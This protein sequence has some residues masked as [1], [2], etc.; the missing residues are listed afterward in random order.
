MIKYTLTFC[1]LI[2]SIFASGQTNSPYFNTGAV[3]F[4]SSAAEIG[5]YKNP[6]SKDLV[7]ISGREYGIIKRVGSNDEPFLSY[8]S[9]D[10]NNNV[11]NF[12]KKANSKFNEGPLCMT[13]NGKRV[14]FTRNDKKT[15]K[16]TGKK[17]IKL[18][19]AEVNAKGKWSNIQL[20]NMNGRGYSTGHPTISP[21]GKYIVFV[22]DMDDGLGGTDL[23]IASINADG[24]IGEALNLGPKLNTSGQELFPW[25]SPEGQLFFA[26]NGLKGLGGFDLWVTE[27]KNG[28]DVFTPINLESPINSSSDDIAIVYHMNNKGYFSSNREKNND[29]VY[30]FNQLRPIVFKVIVSGIVTDLNTKDTLRDANLEIKNQKGEVISTLLTDKNGAYSITLEPDQTYTVEVKKDNHKNEQFNLSTDFNTPKVK[31][32]VELENRPNV[33]YMGTVTDSKSQLALEGVAVTVIDKE[34]KKIILSIITDKTGNFM[35]AFE[36]LKYGKEQRF[37]ITLEKTDYVSKTLDY[38]NIPT[39]TGEISINNQVDLSIGK[40]EIGADLS[41]LMA[42]K[43]IYFDYGKFDIRPDAAEA[44]DKIVAIM[45]EYPTMVIELDSHTD[46]RGTKNANKKLSE[47]R[48]MASAGYIKTKITTPTRISG[49]GLGESKLKVNCPCEGAVVSPCSEEEHAKNRRTEF[50]IKKVK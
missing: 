47:S 10:E 39:Q 36:N 37:E 2:A 14:Y 7:L 5:V 15:T 42:I 1:V 6:G 40:V 29:D 25:F 28:K 30:S 33:S 24:S 21:D 9:V 4:N 16:T 49:V 45:N 46:C 35:K 48:A 27:I 38:S 19:T 22:S 18:Y 3:T 41:T 13:P 44:L 11:K 17:E 50:I 32:N 31:Q 12:Q 43:E 26:S 20:S 23:Y 8:F 34:T